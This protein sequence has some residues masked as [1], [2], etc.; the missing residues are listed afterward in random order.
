[1][2][3]KIEE[4]VR[5]GARL[6]VLNNGQRFGGQFI[7]YLEGDRISY[8]GEG[9]TMGAALAALAAHV[10]RVNRA[11]DLLAAGA[12][13][14]NGREGSFCVESQSGNGQ[15]EV[16]A[17]AGTCTCPDY[18]KRGGECKHVKAAR[19]F[20]ELD[21]YGRAE[22]TVQTKASWYSG[23][24][25][26]I[27]RGKSARVILTEH[28]PDGGGLLALQVVNG[29]A[30]DLLECGHLDPQ[31]GWVWTLERAEY[32]RWALAMKGGAETPPTPGEPY[33]IQTSGGSVLVN[34]RGAIASGWC[35]RCKNGGLPRLY[36]GGV[37]CIC[38]ATIA[39][40]GEVVL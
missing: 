11:A 39:K 29:K 34:E 30:G 6:K 35:A 13:S 19:Q 8:H 16:D 15:Y 5:D 38:G 2:D 4:L 21:I 33:S 27:W 37:H 40:R 23:E 7:A 26:V 31:R 25:V 17:K 12:V 14:V 32:D 9:G 1:M 36:D 10:K 28:G 24:S 18:Q 3:A 22:L 20:A